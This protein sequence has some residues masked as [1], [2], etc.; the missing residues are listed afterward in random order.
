MTNLKN[1]ILNQA[2]NYIKK[3]KIIIDCFDNSTILECFDL[4]SYKD[5][6]DD[7]NVDVFEL[8]LEVLNNNFKG[9]VLDNNDKIY[10]TNKQKAYKEYISLF[11][12]DRETKSN[13]RY[14]FFKK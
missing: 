8:V 10:Y 13:I 7:N 11:D 12:L 5:Y 6:I 4:S 2:K 3:N 9:V 14:Q 1:E